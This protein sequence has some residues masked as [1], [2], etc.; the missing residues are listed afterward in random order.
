MKAS[1]TY[2]NYKTCVLRCL[3]PR[4]G[5]YCQ[6]ESAKRESRLLG[7]ESETIFEH[8]PIGPSPGFGHRSRTRETPTRPSPRPVWSFRFGTSPFRTTLGR[9]CGSRNSCIPARNASRFILMASANGFRV[10]LRKIPLKGSRTDEAGFLNAARRPSLMWLILGL[11]HS[12]G[13]V[14]T[15]TKRTY[16]CPRRPC[17]RGLKI[18]FRC[19]TENFW[20]VPRNWTFIPSQDDTRMPFLRGLLLSCCLPS[21]LKRP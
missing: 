17:K 19:A 15:N 10:P 13:T 14:N 18:S 16:T 11:L 21:R 4:D 1:L 6:K 5:G 8:N 20:N 7:P 12:R 2:R 9:P 3:A